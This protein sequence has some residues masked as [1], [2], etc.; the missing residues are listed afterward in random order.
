M[1]EFKISDWASILGTVFFILLIAFL[2]FLFIIFVIVRIIRKIYKFPIPAFATRLIDNPF[3]RRL[4]Q[5]PE[6]IAERMQLK[7]GMTVVEIGPGKGSYTKAIAK[8]IQPNGKVF[9]IDIQESIIN[10]LKKKIKKENIQNIIPKIEDAYNLSF[11]DESVDRIFAITCLPE[12]PDPI[13]ALRE[14]K[15]ILKPDGI[16]SL[17]E[18]FLDPDYPLR[19]TEKRWAKEAGLDFYEGFGNW[20]VYQLNFI[21]KKPS[22]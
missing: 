10:R 15:R 19:R 7:P 18:L 8:K 4:I 14:F 13:R 3:R 20:F 16:I 22:Y 21:K 9:A 12:I 17:S 2:C 11:E 1:G 6:L 5:K